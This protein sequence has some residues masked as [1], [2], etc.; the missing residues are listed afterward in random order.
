MVMLVIFFNMILIMARGNVN[1]MFF[2]LLAIA[3]ILNFHNLLGVNSD[4]RCS[5]Y[6]PNHG[7]SLILNNILKII[8][9]V[10]FDN[11]L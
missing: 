5:E 4:L 9:A 1:N 8:L 10:I 11:V 2:F 7:I 3:V 6:N